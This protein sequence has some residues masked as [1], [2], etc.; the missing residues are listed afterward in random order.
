MTPNIVS[1]CTVPSSCT[2]EASRP[3]CP[4]VN[5]VENVIV[6]VENWGQNSTGESPS[7]SVQNPVMFLRACC[8]LLR[9]LLL[10]KLRTRLFGL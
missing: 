1:G 7:I 5:F 2:K 4:G 3:V 10:L 6:K 8:L 9:G